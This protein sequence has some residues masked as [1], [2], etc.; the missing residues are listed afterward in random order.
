MKP[1]LDRLL[2][3][4]DLLGQLQELQN[5]N[6]Q[7]QFDITH[8]LF[9]SQIPQKHFILLRFNH[10][11]KTELFASGT[12][13]DL[14]PDLYLFKAEEL[15]ED[16]LNFKRD[17][18]YL[19]QLR[20]NFLKFCLYEDELIE[21][22]LSQG[23]RVLGS[24]VLTGAQVMKRNLQMELKKSVNNYQPLFLTVKVQEIGKL[25]GFVESKIT[26]GSVLQDCRNTFFRLIE[27]GIVDREGEY[28]TEAFK[29]F[30]VIPQDLKVDQVPDYLSRISFGQFNHLDFFDWRELLFTFAVKGNFTA[31]KRALR[32]QARQRIKLLKN[33][34]PWPVSLKNS[35]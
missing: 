12:V 7:V 13:L 8:L 19:L 23:D 17:F 3:F 2:F 1:E 25:R 20:N 31:Y 22:S 18:S 29:R 24:K 9:N 21:I 27:W 10:N 32:L 15:A 6:K 34:Q 4:D 35:I 5:Q 14:I 33:N 30:K 28:F 16:A 11:E 26:V